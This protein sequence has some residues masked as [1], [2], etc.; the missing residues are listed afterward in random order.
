MKV[1]IL[2]FMI[3][4]WLQQLWDIEVKI[5][6]LFKSILQTPNPPTMFIVKHVGQSCHNTCPFGVHSSQ[7]YLLFTTQIYTSNQEE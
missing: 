2:R 6:F 7:Q 5:L 1:I 3:E 4:V